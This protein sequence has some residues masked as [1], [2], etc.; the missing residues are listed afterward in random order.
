MCRRILIPLTIVL[1]CPLAGGIPATS[2]SCEWSGKR[3]MAKSHAQTGY[4]CRSYKIVH[5]AYINGTCLAISVIIER[6]NYHPYTSSAYCSRYLL[7]KLAFQ[8]RCLKAPRRLSGRWK[9]Y[10]GATRGKGNTSKR[11]PSP[12]RERFFEKKVLRF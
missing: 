6:I 2:A 9:R 7:D 10:G 3:R 11:V 8:A 12:P 1:I 4:P 5:A